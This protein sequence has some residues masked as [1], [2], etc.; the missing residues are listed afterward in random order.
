MGR[1]TTL[2][3]LCGRRRE[4]VATAKNWLQ[5]QTFP[6]PC[7]MWRQNSSPCALRHRK[8]RHSADSCQWRNHV[9]RRP[10]DVRCC[11]ELWR[12]RRVFPVDAA[13]RTQASV[14]PH[15][16]TWLRCA[17]PAS[18][19]WFVSCGERWHLANDAEL[20][21]VDRTTRAAILH[22]GETDVRWYSHAARHAT[23]L[24]SSTN[25]YKQ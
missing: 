19:A 11:T 2:P 24:F 7:Q 1:T 10:S 13:Y 21:Q 23:S 15:S 14:A 8:W 4:A 25:N 18:Q 17:A 6:F 16:V 12:Q 22:L 5:S 20:S 3:C 9:R